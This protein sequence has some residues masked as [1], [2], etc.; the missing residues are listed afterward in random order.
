MT[1][2]IG[3]GTCGSSYN[4][5]LNKTVLF[6]VTAQD[7]SALPALGKRADVD[8]TSIADGAHTIKAVVGDK[9]STRRFTT[10]NTA[11]EIESSVPAAGQRLTSTVA[12]NVKIRMPPV[13]SARRSSRWTARP[14]SRA[15]RS[16][17]ACRPGSTPSRSLRPTRWATPPPVRCASAA[18]ASRTSRP[19]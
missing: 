17:T 18:P 15:T 1:T 6:D 19:S 11:P 10:D 14:S 2:Y 16:A 13:W 8:T 4:A 5:V 7:G 3:D 9:T 12:L